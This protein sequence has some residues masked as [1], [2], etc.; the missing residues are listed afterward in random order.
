MVPYGG[1]DQTAEMFEFPW[2]VIIKTDEPGAIPNPIT[3][4]ASIIDKFWVITSVN[5]VNQTQM[6]KFTLRFGKFTSF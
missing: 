4:E 2:Q 6:E 3:C 1:V 5:C